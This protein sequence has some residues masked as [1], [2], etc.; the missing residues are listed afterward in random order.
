MSIFVKL[1]GAARIS[2]CKP[3]ISL[4]KT[5]EGGKS[6]PTYDRHVTA[7][8]LYMLMLCWMGAWE[9]PRIWSLSHHLVAGPRH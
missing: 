9:S 1:E 2:L 8:A 7:A 3:C 5:G 6:W 4:A